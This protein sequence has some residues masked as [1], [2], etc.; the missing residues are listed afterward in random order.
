MTRPV[1]VLRVRAEP[2]VNVIHSL[3][4][5]LKRGLRDFGLK[6]ISIS[7]EQVNQGKE[8]T[9]MTDMRK[10]TSGFIT[11]DD[12][13]NA[14]IEAVIINVFISEKFGVPVLELDN[15][16]QYTCWNKE[17]R[18]LIRAYGVNDEDWK[19]HKVRLEL[20]PTY[21]DKNGVTKESV[22]LTPVSTR[23]GNAG[24]GTSQ[25]IDPAKLP[26]PVHTSNAPA[27][28]N[29]LDD[30]IPFNRGGES[31]SGRASGSLAPAVTVKA[32]GMHNEGVLR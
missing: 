27:P 15:G 21:N 16:D 11:P 5:W 13:R 32:P 10:F 8:N 6:C 24:N 1:F 23:D 22:M 18:K 14:P 26:A 30:E 9:T 3:R 12:V 31:E 19:G 29:D 17:G 7:E 2:G 25:R 4:A 20:G 28:K